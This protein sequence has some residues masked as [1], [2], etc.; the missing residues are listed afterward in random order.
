MEDNETNNT[1]V[2]KKKRKFF[3]KRVKKERDL[4]FLLPL[5]LIF[6]V[7]VAVFGIYSFARDTIKNN[8]ENAISE[9]LN[10]SIVIT[11]KGQGVIKE[12][13][14]TWQLDLETTLDN[15]TTVMGILAENEFTKITTAIKDT[16]KVIVT[17]LSRRS[18]NEYIAELNDYSYTYTPIRIFPEE[19]DSA[20]YLASYENAIKKAE[21]I[22]PKWNN[23]YRI[24]QVKEL[25]TYF[26][27]ASCSTISE[28]EV[29]FMV[30]KL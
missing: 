17:G 9:T 26:D 4:S 30:T 2:E 3:K 20:A 13:I 11:T 5:L 16:G 1:T 21:L 14:D 23:Q 18:E 24:S 19:S 15:K 6:M 22:L 10:K 28:V 29:S 8:K 12:K 27:T 25:N 7:L